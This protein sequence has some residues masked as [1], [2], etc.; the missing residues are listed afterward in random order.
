MPLEE[1][2][3]V[4]QYVV[5]PTRRSSAEAFQLMLSHALGEA[6]APYIFGLMAG[7]TAEAI[8]GG[9]T[10]DPSKGFCFQFPKRPFDK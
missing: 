7:G 3:I 10:R 2:A 8:K 9:F 5:I 4:Y 6:G 1:L